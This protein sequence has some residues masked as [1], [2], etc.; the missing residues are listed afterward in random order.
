[1]K[2]EIVP[3]KEEYLV[4]KWLTSSFLVNDDEFINFQSEM[5]DFSLFL[6]GRVLSSIDPVSHVDFSPNSL[7]PMLMTY[8]VNHVYAYGVSE[9]NYL[10]YPRFPVIQVREHKFMWTHDDRI[11]TMSSGKDSISWGLNFSYPQIF[12]DPR[13]KK[14]VEVFKEKESP[15]TIGFK[16]LQKWV[17]DFTKPAQFIRGGKKINATFRIGKNCTQPAI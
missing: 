13:I 9:G 11:M 12:Y 5:G 16:K 7:D 3:K 2:I 4:S 17:R 14:I 8:D 10:I 6:T 15:N 1:M